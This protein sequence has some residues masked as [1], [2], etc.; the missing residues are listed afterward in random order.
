M[1]KPKPTLRL[2]EDELPEIKNHT[3][4]KKYHLH[5]EVEMRSHSKGDRYGMDEK[6]EKKKHEGEYVVTSAKEHNE[7]E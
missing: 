1:E 6:G 2:S 3:P 5:L 7:D 4:G